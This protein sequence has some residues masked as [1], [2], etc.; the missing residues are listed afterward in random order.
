MLIKRLIDYSCYNHI[1]MGQLQML[2]DVEIRCFAIMFVLL[3]VASMQ[4]SD[5]KPIGDQRTQ[6]CR[7]NDFLFVD[8]NNSD[9]IF[10]IHYIT[11]IYDGT[12]EGDY[13]L[14]T[15]SILK[16]VRIIGV[17]LATTYRLYIIT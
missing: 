2:R 11:C 6:H 9:A 10:C 13:A 8:I 14:I 15:E 1:P 7:L 17:V 16:S 12:S 3:L 4:L 5:H